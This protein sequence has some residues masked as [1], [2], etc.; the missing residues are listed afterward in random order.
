M[1]NNLKYIISLLLIFSLTVNECLLYSQSN[2]TS[3]YQTSELVKRNSLTSDSKLYFFDKAPTNK[4]LQLFFVFTSVKFQYYLK[5]QVRI[6]LKLQ[7]IVRFNIRD[8]NSEIFTRYILN[9]FEK[10]HKDLYIG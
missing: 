5:E 10:N 1:K 3:Y 7:A 4:I 2:S 6:I 9:N 8:L